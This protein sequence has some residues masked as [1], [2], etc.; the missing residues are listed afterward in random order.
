MSIESSVR[1]TLLGLVAIAM[2]LFVVSAAASS[3]APGDRPTVKRVQIEWTDPASGPVMYKEYC[4]ACHGSAAKG[5]GPAAVALKTMPTDLTQLSAKKDGKF[6]AIQA[7][8]VV[9]TT[10]PISQRQP[11]LA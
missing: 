11:P 2:V 8:N 3:Q 6:D 9:N 5:D 4:A 10:T 1:T 7:T